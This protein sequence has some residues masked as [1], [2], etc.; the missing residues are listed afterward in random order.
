MRPTERLRS[1]RAFHD[2]QAKYRALALSDQNL[3][4][5]DADYL[6]HETWI[7]P[8]LAQ[9]GDVRGRRVLD[10]GC[11]HGMASVVLARRGASVVGLDL[12][13]GYLKEA[14]RR[15]KANGVGV[16][17]VHANAEELPFRDASFAGV[18]GN[19]ILH[20]L[21]LT[22][23]A[24][25]LRRVL[26]PGGKVVFCEP[27]GENPLL[28][29]ARRYCPYPGKRR[30]P[31]ELPLRAGHVRTLRRFFPEIKV[32]GEQLLSMVGRLLGP[33][34]RGGALAACDRALLAC[35][36]SLKRYCR[37]VVLTMG[38]AEVGGG[39]GAQRASQKNPK[40]NK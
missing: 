28:A 15:A 37:Y 27:W 33:K 39:R 20:H 7:E 31:D 40:K 8:A 18:W 14:R 5:A 25:E 32:H 16:E 22:K 24:R 2:E 21:D 1:E 34:A 35:F 36:P 3:R 29:W 26:V 13:T 38:R 23:A 17:F 30:T 19:A 6:K 11:G 4:F 12:S 9:L 10:L